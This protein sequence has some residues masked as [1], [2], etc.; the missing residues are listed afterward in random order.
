MNHI[1][2]VHFADLHSDL[3]NTKLRLRSSALEVDVDRAPPG[4]RLSVML[5]PMAVT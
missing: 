2:S 4:R 1:V 3:A 5:M